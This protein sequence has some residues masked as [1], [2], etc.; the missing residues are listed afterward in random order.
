MMAETCGT[1]RFYKP[2]ARKQFAEKH[3]V[4]R[5]FP[6]QVNYAQN[7]DSWEAMQDEPYMSID[8]WCG[9]FSPTPP[10]SAQEEI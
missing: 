1:C 4:C 2:D 9:E 5:R 6:P 10:V 7:F 8:D 3:G